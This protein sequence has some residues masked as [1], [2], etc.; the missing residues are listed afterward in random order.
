[1]ASHTKKAKRVRGRKAAPNKVNLKANLKRI[2][3]NAEK[4]LKPL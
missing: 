1:M 3:K 2:Q 4:S